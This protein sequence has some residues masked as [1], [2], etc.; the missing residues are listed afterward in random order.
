MR[1]YRG[2]AQSLSCVRLRPLLWLFGHLLD[3]GTVPA[4]TRCE[5]LEASGPGAPTLSA[6]ELAKEYAK[7]VAA[8]QKK[9]DNKWLILTGEVDKVEKGKQELGEAARVVFKTEAG[10]RVECGLF[11]AY[12][13][14][15]PSLK[16]GQKLKVL[17]EYDH[18][19][20][21][22]DLVSLSS[23]VLLEGGK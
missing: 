13:E 8:A 21:T 23:G 5:V 15:I 4:L 18:A 19:Y 1:R 10:P 12:K 16:P 3:F 2:I 6:D 9:Y 14:K 7:D 11:G 22:K 20:S 17:G